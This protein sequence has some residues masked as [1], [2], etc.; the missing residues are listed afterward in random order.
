MIA[1]CLIEQECYQE[2]LDE[3]SIA[4][5]IFRGADVFWNRHVHMDRGIIHARRGELKRAEEE[6][7]SVMG[8]SGSQNRRISIAGIL[9][10]LGRADEAIDWL[11]AAATAREPHV[12]ALLKVPTFDQLRPHPRYQALLRRI[13]LAN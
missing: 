2:A 5:G 9:N 1:K 8:C 6:L 11:E 4:E 7:A 13:G 10:A 3:L 12:A